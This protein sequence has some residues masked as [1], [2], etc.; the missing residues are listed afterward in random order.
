M[1]FGLLHVQSHRSSSGDLW[2]AA[3]IAGRAEIEAGCNL[4]ARITELIAICV[5]CEARIMFYH[6]GK[7]HFLDPYCLL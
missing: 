4:F 2:E 6:F 3:T 5:P 1:L 7:S